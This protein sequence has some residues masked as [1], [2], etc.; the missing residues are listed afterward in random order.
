MR[1]LRNICLSIILGSVFVIVSCDDLASDDRENPKIH[2]IR[3]NMN[4]T[5]FLLDDVVAAR[6]QN[7]YIAM[8]NSQKD[9][10]IPD[11]IVLGRPLTISGT[12]SDNQ[13]LSAIFVRIYGDTLIESNV[14]DTCYRIKKSPSVYLN[15]KLEDTIRKVIVDQEVRPKLT[16]TRDGEVTELEI[17]PS[18][19]YLN[20]GKNNEYFYSVKCI[21][22]AGNEDSVSFLKKPI[23]LLTEDEVKAATQDKIWY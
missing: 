16:V 1:V 4:D 19:V 2:S 23:Y 20:Q 18:S 5:I 10:D 8:N 17:R 15:G 9:L 13:G 21:D 22:I 7:G 6:K 3:F 14:S 11:T 12:F